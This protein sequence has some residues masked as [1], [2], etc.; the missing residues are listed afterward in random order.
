MEKWHTSLLLSVVTVSFMISVTKSQNDL[1][2]TESTTISTISSSTTAAPNVSCSSFNNDCKGCVANSG[3]Y[4]CDSDKR[5]NNHLLDIISD[6]ECNI[7]NVHYKTCKLNFKY[8]MII[9]GSLIGV[10]LLAILIFC[11]YCCCKRRG[12]SFSK[13]EL[14][15]ARQKEER[16]A[17]SA[18]RR[19]ERNERTEEIRRKYGLVK[20]SNPY[21]KFD[22]EA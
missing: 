2:S 15:W 21:Q 22:D 13:D 17:A 10:A 11:C 6:G 18:E 20:D 8:L 19:R 5:C 7:N 9:I 14:K 16:K 3:C 4:Y 12:V 1:N